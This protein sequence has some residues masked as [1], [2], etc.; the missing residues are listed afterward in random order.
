MIT[1]GKS[2]QVL[3]GG[4][5]GKHGIIIVVVFTH[6]NHSKS[7]PQCYCNNHAWH[8]KS[9]IHSENNAGGQVDRRRD[10]FTFYTYMSCSS[11]QAAAPFSRS[12]VRMVLMICAVRINLIIMRVFIRVTQLWVRQAL[13]SRCVG[14]QHIISHEQ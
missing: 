3:Q 2:H 14:K 7:S 12:L 6:T 1:L 11:S 10:F 4:L 9:E 13:E 8:V 5:K